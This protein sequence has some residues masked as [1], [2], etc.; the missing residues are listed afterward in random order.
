MN[1]VLNGQGHGDVASV[2]MENNFDTR[3]LRPFIGRDGRN[4]VSQDGPTNNEGQPTEQAMVTNAPA[5]LRKDDWIAL[6]T[7]VLKVAKQR[8]KLVKGLTQSGLT[9]SV[10]NG[11]GTTVLQHERQ[12]DLT[13]A[14]TSMDGMR[15][16]DSDR[17]EFDIVNLPLPIVHKDFQYSLRQIQASRSGGSP[18]DTTSAELAARLVAEQIEKLHLGESAGIT[19]GGG[20]VYGMKNFPQR[21][22]KAMT[23]PT[24]SNH[25]VTVNEVLD[26]RTQSQDNGYYGPWKL[27]CSTVWD[28]YLDE[29]YSAAKGDNT[30]RE[31][32][33]KIEGI[34]AV[35]TV[36]YLTGNDMLL[37][38]Q[39]SDVI[40][41]VTGLAMTTLQWPSKGGLQLNYKVMAIMVPQ[42]RADFNDQTGIVHGTF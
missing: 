14:I 9:F 10:P 29:D 12:S 38:Q 37:V 1:Y 16:G 26:M 41:T 30:L 6:D 20:T 7:A 19:Y 13:P 42:L 4:Y 34:Q 39:T 3:M 8:L 36:D 2:L 33:A 11:I 35:E 21:L 27:Y 15:E 40:R 24:S 18:L 28:Q 32:L 25:D 5:T 23:T 22:T 17:P 31:R